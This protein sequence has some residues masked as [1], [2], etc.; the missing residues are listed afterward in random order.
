MIT[1]R[2]KGMPLDPRPDG[3]PRQVDAEGLT[4]LTLDEAKHDPFAFCNYVAGKLGYKPPSAEI[5]REAMQRVNA[6]REMYDAQK[7]KAEA[8]DRR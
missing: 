7:K 5:E 8:R 1:V 6:A 4:V 2:S 3:K